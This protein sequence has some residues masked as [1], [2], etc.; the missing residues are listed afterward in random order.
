MPTSTV[1]VLK[2]VL[3]LLRQTFGEVLVVDVRPA[4][5]KSYQQKMG[6]RG[7]ARG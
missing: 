1:A 5:L 3:R 7:A 6:E 2:P 4:H